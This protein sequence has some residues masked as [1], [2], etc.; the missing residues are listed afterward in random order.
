MFGTGFE[1]KITWF[2]GRAVGEQK[3]TFQ[4]VAQLANISRPVI[5]HAA[6]PRALVESSARGRA[7]SEQIRLSR[8]CAIA[9]I[10]SWRS[11]S[12]GIAKGTVLMRKYKIAAKHFRLDQVPKILVG[13]SDQA[14][15][16]E[17]IA[18]VSHPAESLFF[19]YLQ[20]LGLDIGID[21]S[22]LIE[23]KSPAMTDLEQTRLGIDGPGKCTALVA[24]QLRFEEFA[25]EPGTIQ[26]DKGFL[27]ARPIFVKPGRQ[28]ALAGTG[29]ALN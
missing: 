3:S 9:G 6:D 8:V 7:I 11:R 19:H 23:K 14:H 4:D 18:Y 25:G 5:R 29:L 16:D 26:I 28:N 2:E 27:R 13:G 22:D 12:G 1:G 24:K 20:Q 17:A 10:S 15:I 21:I